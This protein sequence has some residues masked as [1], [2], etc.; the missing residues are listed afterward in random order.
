MSDYCCS[1]CGRDV[2]GFL[3]CVE[4]G[5]SVI[6][7]WPTWC[8]ERVC[9]DCKPGY[10]QSWFDQLEPDVREAIGDLETF[11]RL[12]VWRPLGLHDSI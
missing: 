10:L 8:D 5:E 3:T 7:Q 12:L 11:E 4:C 6:L 2:A 9:D 1:E